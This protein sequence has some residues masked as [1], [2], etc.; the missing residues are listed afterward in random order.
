ME[1][2]VPSYWFIFSTI[3]KH[4][5]RQMLLI[6]P[7]NI[8]SYYFLHKCFLYHN[9]RICIYVLFEG[10]WRNFPKALDKKTFIN[11]NITFYETVFMILSEYRR[12]KHKQWNQIETPN[13]IFLFLYR[14]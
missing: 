6:K 7:L 13:I 10:I 12:D 3:F 9:L 4:E 1:N 11:N 14:G 8:F 5:Y 2:I